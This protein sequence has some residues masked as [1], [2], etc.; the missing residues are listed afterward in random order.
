MYKIREAVIEIRYDQSLLFE[1]NSK[2]NNIFKTLKPNF[3]QFQRD[4]Q[5]RIFINRREKMF[6]AVLPNRSS[7]VANDI[8]AI[9][10]L[11]NKANEAFE[12][13][14]RELDIDNYTRV[15]LRQKFAVEVDSY[16][17]INSK[18]RSTFF[19]KIPFQTFN[20]RV[21]FSTSEGAKGINIYVY[22]STDVS[23][24]ISDHKEFARRKHYIIFD[25]DVFIEQSMATNSLNAFIREANKVACNKLN[26]LKSI[27]IGEE[28]YG[29]G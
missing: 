15:G 5:A 21:S 3:P 28:V 10:T 16:Q 11:K 25:L 6:V 20:P 19:E 14:S 26:E 1:D 22:P 7:A 4:N 12:A 23:I 13:I 29:E 18:I 2:L 9:G 17:E 8:N 24:E 27:I